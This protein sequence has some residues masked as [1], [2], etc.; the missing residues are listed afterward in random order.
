MTTLAL[1]LST[2]LQ[3][4]LYAGAGTHNGIYAYAVYWDASGTRHLTQLVD[5][6]AATAAL[7]GGTA[8]IDLPQ[9]SGGKIYFLIQDRDPSDT[10]T[11]ISTAITTESQ[12]SSASA[13]TLNY[14]YDS[15]EFTLSGTTGDAGNLTSVNGFGLPMELA[16][17][18]QSA[19]YKISGAAMFSAL[20]GTAS[21]VSSTFASVGGALDGLGRMINAPAGDSTAFPASDW[22]AYVEG[23]KT[24]EPGLIVSGLFNGAPDANNAWHNAGYFAYTLTWDPTHANIDGTTGTFWL[25]PTD[26]SQIKGYI[27]ITPAELENSIYQTLG[28][29]YVYQNK[30]DASP[31]TIAYSGTDAMNVGANNQWGEVLTQFVTGFSAGYFGALGT[32]LNSGVTTPVHLNNSINWDPTY[33]F[34]NNVNYG[35]AAHFWDHYSAVFYANSNSYGSNY[36]DN[37]MSQY[38]QGGPLISLYDAAT[39]TNVSTINLTLYDLFDATDV[40]A[41]YVT[42]TINNYIAG[43]YTPVSATTSGANISLSFSDG[44]VVLDESDTAVTLRFQTAAGVWQ[45][46]MLSSANNTN[47]NTLWDTWTIVNNNGTWSANGANAGQPAGS[48]NITNPPLP[49]GGTGWYQIVVQNTAATT[50]KTYNLYVS[51]SGGS[52]SA[53]A[54]AIDGLAHIGS[55]TASNLA[56]AFFNGSGSSL[57]PA[58]LTD[59]TLSTNATAF[60]NLHNGYVQPF[61]PV[62]GDMSSGAFA[63]LGGQTL[64]STAAP[65][66]MTAAATGSGQLAF[67]WS[68][69]DPSNWWSAA[70]NASHGGLAPPVAHYTNRVGAQNTALVSV[71]ETDGSYNT[72]LFSL[73]DIDGL[74]FTPTLK[75]GNGTYTAQ[76]TEYLPGGI[77]PAYQMAPTS[78]QVTFT[79]NIPTLGLS[80]S[81][82][83]LELDTTVAPGVNGN[84]IRFSASASGSTLPKDSTLLLYATDALGNLVGRD[85]HTGAGV[86]LADATLGKIGVIV[87][88]SGQLLFSG[89]QQLHLAAGL[90]L[91][92]A[93]ESGNGSVDM[94]PM[95]MVTAGSDGTAHIIVGGMVLTAQTLNDLT[96][97]A[98]LAQTQNE[99]D[100]PLLYLTHGETLSLDISGSGANTNTLGFVHMETDG[101]GHY[102]VGGVAY[103]DTDAFRAAVLANF[104][105]GTTFVRGGE[106]AFSASWTVA[107]TDGFYAPVLLTPH[108]DVL[109]VGHA[110]AGGYEY[111]RMYG[112]NTF[113]FEDVTAARGSDFDYNDLAMRITPLAPV[114]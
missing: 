111:I 45:E 90:Q 77:T 96:D 106:T 54:P 23:F 42:P 60:A 64:N 114:V 76:M 15:F 34:G 85:G 51:A 41:G 70:D 105:G 89:L 38:D 67:S 20:S 33:A 36:S 58:L 72:Q 39:S 57:N 12:I 28:T 80:A 44:Y 6:G 16:V 74:W 22:S 61:A 93:V 35:A 29:A 94:S 86:T 10:S 75:L 56:I 88:D 31:Y 84:W 18:S 109:V 49:D 13:T 37:V 14:R 98:Q 21:G 63:A 53:T 108:G 71:A 101:A 73:V 112:E 66:A 52:F 5:N 30:T 43:P 78:A 99:T 79:V 113:A 26:Q 91:H 3:D 69:S 82:A 47:G 83:A 97:A 92:F 100:L 55:A 103:G 7:S 17:G 68:G 4:T 65:V 107:G 81:G 110:H 50:V 2:K 102:S 32:P 62:V 104:D 48:I 11:D 1:Q 59:L 87:S 24:S 95:T 9:M 19:S 25:S 27:Q 46:V 8:S 40:P